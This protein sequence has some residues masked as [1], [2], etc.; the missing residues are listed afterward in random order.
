[1]V[2]RGIIAVALAGM[3]CS[4][5]TSDPAATAGT[6]GSAASGG[7]GG[8]SAGAGG[9][10]GT[11]GIAGSA[12]AG[13]AAGSSGGAGHPGVID[14]STLEQKLVMGYQGWFLCPG[15]GAPPD[16]WVHWFKSQNPVA[17]ELAVEMWPDTSEL[18]AAELFDTGLTVAGGQTARLYSAWNEATVVRHFSWMKDHGIDGVLVQRFV[19]ELSDPKFLAYRDRVLEN[20]RAGAEAHGRVFAVMYDISGAGE[21]TLVDALK[22]DWAHLTGTLGILQ[23]PR[24]LHHAG[25]PVVAI[26]GLG[27][28]DRPGTAAQAAAIVDHFEDAT[29]IGGVPTH[30]RTLAGD[31]KTDPAWADV[32]RSFDVLSPWLVGRFA[33]EAGADA[34]LAD[35]IVPDLAETQGHGIGYLPVT[36]PGF[37]WNNLNAGPLNQIP[38]HGGKFYWRQVH[39]AIAAGSTMLYTA[40]FDEVDEATA[41]YK[42]A[43]TA[44]EAPIEGTF[45]TLD[46]DGQALPSDWYLRVGGEATRMLRGDIPLSATIPISP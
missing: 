41:M 14:A 7:A 6:A 44:A 40:M 33:D 13:G 32:Y 20:A 17:S 42:V 5:S 18:G 27:F 39:N 26:W 21:S 46:A 25:N 31:S 10:G 24:Y 15:D 8:S 34:A 29:L 16:R 35:W 23:S 11:A 28:S 30:W 4:E 3:G 2:A 22:N 1:M 19:S 9:T 38:R 36:F 12:G 37:S 45:L 43:P